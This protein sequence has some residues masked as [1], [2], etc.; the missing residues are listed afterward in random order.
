VGGTY[1]F[2]TREGNDS[3]GTLRPD[4]DVVITAWPVDASGNVATEEDGRITV[5]AISRVIAGG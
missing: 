3:D 2:W 5:D 4:L 1:V